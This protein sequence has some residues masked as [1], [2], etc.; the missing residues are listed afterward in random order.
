M[1]LAGP[2]VV[3]AL[4]A[5]VAAG[6]GGGGT[7]LTKAQYEQ[8]IQA[9]GKA[10]QQA[11]A[12]ISASA[13][14]PAKLAVQ[15][16]AADDAAKKAAG[17]LDAAKPPAE[18]DA[19]NTKIVAGLRAIDAVLKKLELGVK[20]GDAAIAQHD[21]ASALLGSAEVKAAAAAAQDMKKQGYKVGVIG[22]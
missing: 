2:V 9:D 10:V 4:G 14:S 1:R 5:L 11:V 18:I 17:D 20:A 7:Q 16:A 8:K 21:A 15:V 12:S 19:D 22:K 3:V 6:C 13:S